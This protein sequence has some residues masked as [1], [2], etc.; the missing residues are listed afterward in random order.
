M[1][2]LQIVP[3]LD[4]GGVE[5]GTIDLAR[6][7]TLNAHK[8][9]VISG[10]GKLVKQL[11][12][13]GARHY[14]LPVGKKNPLVMLAMV[15]A[16]V[17][18]IKKEN[19]D[20]VHARSRVP[21]LTGF[22]AAR[23][24]RKTFITTAH[25]QYRRHLL[26]YVMGWGRVVIVASP[27]MARHM[28]DTFGVRPD[29]IRI[30]PRGVDTV[31]FACKTGRKPERPFTVGMIARFSPLKGHTD[32]IQ[33]VALLSRSV[34]KLRAV[35]V[36]DRSG[37]RAAYVSEL[38]LLAKRLGV[39]GTIRF[40][41]DTDDVVPVLAELD[42]L[43]SASRE[44]EA[45]GRT[46]IEAAS[47]GVPCVATR[48]GGVT[49]I[50]EDGVTGLLCEPVSPRDMALKISRL[51]T[52]PAL[53][54]NIRD[55]AR[56]AVEKNFSLDKMM[57]STVS[58]YE[59]AMNERRILIIKISSLGDVLLSM[60][61][62][63]AVRGKYPKAVI[64]VLVGAESRDVFKNCPYA[65]EIIYCDLKGVNRGIKGLTCLGDRLRSEDFDIVIDLQNSRK[66]HILS[67]LSGAPERLGYDNGKWSFLLSKKAHD[68][69]MP[70]NPID[71]QMR[72][73]A[74]TGIGDM[75]RRLALFTSQDDEEW[76]GA[77][78][79][80]NWINP[81]V[82]FLALNLGASARWA[83]KLWPVENFVEVAERLARDMGMRTVVIGNDPGDKRI[84]DFMARARSKPVSAAGRTTVGQLIA[85][86]KRAGV[87]IT[88]DSAPMHAASGVGTPFVALFGPT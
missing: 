56:A 27:V 6:Y 37:R 31:R 79:A 59:E 33:A 17:R 12:E 28:V 67:L 5:T 87:L 44:Q 35:M 72:V 45:F 76:A 42:V 51:H 78:L 65:D 26:S 80:E 23:L 54:E 1:N 38:E 20:V 40:Q 49:D 68:T 7:L 73:L 50:I 64:K 55:N 77:F 9:V 25:G 18:V 85:L 30:I 48:V 2:I 16:I 11:D 15:W 32:F 83:T 53:Y 58:V 41:G 52:D 24:T 29:K 84:K 57:T 86:L 81:K 10:G 47:A 74:L 22:I 43:V 61:S 75:D 82:P 36:G 21:A 34:P 19:A 69:G 66:S 63:R 3:K 71:H 14:T 62:V 70:L 88:S 60:P 46:I 13:V 4:V 8:A 39:A